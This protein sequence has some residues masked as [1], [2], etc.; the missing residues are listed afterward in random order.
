MAVDNWSDK[1]SKVVDILQLLRQ[2]IKF[3]P[4][5]KS[6]RL[7]DAKHEL[8]VI[9]ITDFRLQSFIVVQASGRDDAFFAVKN[10]LGNRV[11]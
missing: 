6:S 10:R 9:C 8:S 5:R 7:G 1:L 2:I 11:K 4:Y 3:E